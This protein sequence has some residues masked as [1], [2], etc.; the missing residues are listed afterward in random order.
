LWVSA[1]RL[2]PAVVGV[3]LARFPTPFKPFRVRCYLINRL[4]ATD[5]F[6]PSCARSCEC[7]DRA[8]V[9]SEKRRIVRQGA[10]SSRIRRGGPW[11]QAAVCIYSTRLRDSGSRCITL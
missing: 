7:C 6:R 9:E 5:R 1:L 10:R 4:W 3:V 2:A 8:T 11:S